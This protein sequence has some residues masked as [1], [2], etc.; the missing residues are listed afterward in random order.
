MPS[1]SP[2]P[3][4]WDGLVGEEESAPAGADVRPEGDLGPVAAQGVALGAG[5]PAAQLGHLVGAAGLAV[6]LHLQIV[7]VA[8][9]VALKLEEQRGFL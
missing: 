5:D 6:V 3:A 4:G 8:V 7:I 2:P 1:S 9:G